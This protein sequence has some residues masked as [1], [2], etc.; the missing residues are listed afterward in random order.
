MST[1]LHRV[2]VCPLDWGLGHASRM[3]PVIRSYIQHGYK[4][5]L[6]GTGKSGALLKLTFPDLTFI[7]IPSYPIRYS[8][9]GIWLIPSLT[10]Q[11]PLMLLSTLREHYRIKKIVKT[12][13]IQ[14]IVSDNRY[15]LYCRQAHS[16]FVTH[17]ISPVLPPFLKWAEFPISIIL[18]SII[19]RF[20]ECW[21]PDHADAY[22]NLSGKLSHRFKLPQNARYVGILSRFERNSHFSKDNAEEIFSLVAITSGPEP[23]RSLFSEMIIAQALKLPFRILVINGLSEN[24]PDLPEVH[25]LL[26]IVPHLEPDEFAE[27]LMK[28]DKI[29]CRS[30]YS[31]IMD[32]IAIG[33]TALLV[34]T[35]GQ[36]EQQYLAKNLAG[37]GWFSYVS[38]S[39]LSLTNVFNTPLNTLSPIGLQINHQCNLPI[40]SPLD[41]K[42]SDHD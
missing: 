3:I 32:L 42:N 4:V 5:L 10:L 1:D 29:I 16:I 27:V 12:Y 37:K 25:S 14:I 23:Q 11:L 20:D 22:F 7:S 38:Q 41:H 2:I 39:E 9:R 15:G 8:S 18:R 26:K 35:P 28:A 6:G 40:Q 31:S 34:P 36:T 19:C 17:Q 13:H 30:G 33:R 24:L 21:I